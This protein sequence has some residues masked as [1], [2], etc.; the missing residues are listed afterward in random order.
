VLLRFSLKIKTLAE[1]GNYLGAGEEHLRGQSAWARALGKNCGNFFH[2]TRREF[3]TGRAIHLPEKRFRPNFRFKAAAP[4]ALAK[5]QWTGR[6]R[7]PKGRGG[8]SGFKP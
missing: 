3:R 8:P 1:V 7:L 6:G 2:E 4:W 5:I